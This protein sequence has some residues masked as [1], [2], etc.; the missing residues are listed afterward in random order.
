MSLLSFNV[1]KQGKLEGFLKQQSVAVVAAITKT[2]DAIIAVV[3]LSLLIA[4]V[5]T[6]KES[7]GSLSVIS[8]GAPTKS[9]FTASKDL[10]TKISQKVSPW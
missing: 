5:S 1:L 8:F 9:I 7:G 2:V 4:F 3:E 10:F 6:I